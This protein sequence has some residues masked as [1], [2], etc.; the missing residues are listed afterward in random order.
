MQCDPSATATAQEELVRST[1]V[2]SV[3]PIYAH[4]MT[5]SSS[6]ERVDGAKLIVRPPPGMSA[7]QMT[8]VLQCHS[9][10]ALLGQVNR[11][12]VRNDPYWLADRWVSIEVKPENG[13]F[14]ITLSADSVRDN[15]EVL[16]HASGFASDHAVALEPELP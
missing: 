4:I 8:R 1:K 11:D 12:A 13:N 14:A 15:L 6:E 2:L 3:E 16:N 9:A 5:A 7:E 10:R